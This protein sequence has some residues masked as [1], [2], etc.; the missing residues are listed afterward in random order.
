MSN[1]DILFKG[2]PRSPTR[3]FTAA[4]LRQL[5]PEKA[6]IPCA[7]AFALASTA[8][9][10][11]IA[12]KNIYCCDI[13]LYSSVLGY[14][15]SDDP[16]F[17]V[18]LHSLS[19]LA[20]LAPYLEESAASQVA[21]VTVGIRLIQLLSKSDSVYR[22]HRL[23][24]MVLRIEEMIEQ[25]RAA[26]ERN[27]KLLGGLHYITEDMWD[28]LARH[29]DDETAVILCNPPRYTGGY[30]KMYEGVGEHFIWD[31]PRVQQ[32]TANDYPILT[33][34]LGHARAT[35]LLYY[36]TPTVGGGDPAP[37]WGAPWV[38][39]FAAR[40]RTGVSAA[41]NWVVANRPLTSA[42]ARQD[43]GR[44]A[45]KPPYPVLLDEEIAPDSVLEVRTE[46]R[47]VAEYYRDLLVHNL[48][49]SNAERWFVLLLDG[50][51][52]AV[53]GM[54]TKDW[55]AG[56]GS[57]VPKLVYL[58]TAPHKRYKRLQKLA[59]LAVTSTWF[60]D[61][62][63]RND[64]RDAP[65]YVSTTM[66]SNYPEVKTARGILRLRE[67]EEINQGGFRYRLVYDGD[68]IARTAAD[69]L[70]E[71]FRRWETASSQGSTAAAGPAKEKRIQ[72]AAV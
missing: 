47:A 64:L 15:Y 5:R 60:Y 38:S 42:L 34:Y 35:V 48:P 58:F 62:L 46:G 11:G 30:D 68:V 31:A 33:Q 18:Q 54:T 27:R 24:D 61:R 40:P 25:A 63:D 3:G 52:L 37:A 69:T 59:L 26:A 1:P 65:P 41:I 8:V 22:A 9:Q 6:I 19:E 13:T 56:S 67:R 43:T 23:R 72:E 2:V 21:A 32:F 20:F 57:E 36:S 12:P 44:P 29:V 39:V 14:Y 28:L 4:A 49:A 55:L 53:G 70:G 16:I 51:L 71:W 50:R 66:L 17:P 10:A 7:G 45:V